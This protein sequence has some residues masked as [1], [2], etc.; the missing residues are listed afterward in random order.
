MGTIYNNTKEIP[1]Y[2]K[3]PNGCYRGNYNG[4]IVMSF[5]EDDITMKIQI[6]S[7]RVSNDSTWTNLN[8]G[9]SEKEVLINEITY[10]N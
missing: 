3:Q 10:F 9:F 8:N 2:L 1:N 4:K 5:I 6:R 7:L